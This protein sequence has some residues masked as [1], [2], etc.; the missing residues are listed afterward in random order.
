[1][2]ILAGILALALIPLIVFV[3]RIVD[4][5]VFVYKVFPALI[6]YKSPGPPH[7]GQAFL[8]YIL[9]A[10]SYKDDIGL[11]AHELTHV[12]QFYRTFCLHGIL[13]ALSTAYRLYAELEAYAEQMKYS[14]DNIDQFA[15]FISTRYG[16]DISVP[17]AHA[18][19]RQRCAA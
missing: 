8:F 2:I 1:M 15:E 10:P 6:T 11:L 12:K 13:Y 17:E 9:I 19:L 18:K 4:K 16:F 14:P 5:V 3:S 7:H